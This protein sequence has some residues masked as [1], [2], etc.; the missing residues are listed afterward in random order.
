MLPQPLCAGV[1][2]VLR[3]QQVWVMN[4]RVFW[5][6]HELMLDLAKTERCW[7]ALVAVFSSYDSIFRTTVLTAAWT[8]SEKHLKAVC[9][10][11]H[12]HSCVS[13]V[14]AQPGR[15]LCEWGGEWQT[16]PCEWKHSKLHVVP[17]ASV[18]IS[19][20]WIFWVKQTNRQRWATDHLA[21]VILDVQRK[22]HFCKRGSCRK[23]KPF[24]CCCVIKTA[25]I[26]GSS[27]TCS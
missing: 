19:Q 21:T 16:L 26:Q 11:Q 22:P 4:N 9:A 20:S 12:L 8:D 27:N 15:E 24:I 14:N 13:H 2:S 18:H 7:L 5:I 1:D 17:T 3:V 6:K 10:E 23:A 25:W